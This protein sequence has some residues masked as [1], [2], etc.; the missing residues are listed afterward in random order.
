MSEVQV[1]EEAIPAAAQPQQADAVRAV[2]DDDG[3]LDADRLRSVEAE[4]VGRGAFQELAQLYAGAAERAA[5]PAVGRQ[6]G[7]IAAA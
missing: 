3:L 1:S 5:E 2:L 4:L 6:M 7:N